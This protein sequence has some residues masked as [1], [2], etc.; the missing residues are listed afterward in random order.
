MG[1]SIIEN[2]EDEKYL[3]DKVNENG[4]EASITETIKERIRTLTSKGH[5]IIQISESPLMGG[6]GNSTA[7]FKLFDANNSRIAYDKLC[8]MDRTHRKQGS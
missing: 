4:C 1:N 8:I 3:G 6:L 7:P 2:S 5:D